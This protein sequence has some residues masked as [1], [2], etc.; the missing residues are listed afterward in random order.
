LCEIINS[1]VKEIVMAE[2][3]PLKRVK[4]GEVLA[5]VAAGFAYAMGWSVLM[6]RV[7]GGAAI[8]VLRGQETYY[9]GEVAL[10]A[11]GLAAL[12]A[13]YWETDPEDFEART[14]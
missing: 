4:T 11:Y 1:T 3:K 6:V 2:R 10:V 7:L 8:L 13:P 9:I 12:L 14:A 5:G